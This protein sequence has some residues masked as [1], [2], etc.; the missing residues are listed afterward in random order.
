MFAS[1]NV[2]DHRGKGEKFRGCTDEL[3]MP[4]LVTLEMKLLM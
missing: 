2:N 3:G 4:N 1:R